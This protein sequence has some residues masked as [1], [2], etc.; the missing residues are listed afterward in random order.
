MSLGFLR[1]RLDALPIL[2]ALLV[3]LPACDS[4]DPPPEEE[5]TDVVVSGVNFTR[6]FAPATDGEVAAVRA[7]WSMRNPSSSNESVVATTT[8][9]GATLAVVE[10]TVTASG[11]APVTHYGLVRV[12]DG[13]DDAPVLVVHHGG[14]DG[15]SVSAGSSNT[16]VVQ[17]VS[18]FGAVA[19]DVVLVVPVYRSET[20]STAGVGGLGASYTAGGTPS[21]WDYDVD[22]SIAMLDAALALFD[23]E[24]DGDRVA[25][26]G[27]SRGG[28]TAALH[29]VRDDRIDGLVDYYGPTDFFNADGAQFLA[30][31]LLA[32]EPDAPN[33]P[34]IGLP[35]AQY[36]YDEV[37]DALRDGRVSEADARLE[38]VRRSASVFQADLPATQVHHHYRDGV[39]TV[40][41]SLAFQA[42]AEGGDGGPFEAF[43]YG[44]PATGTADL[45]GTFHSPD[46]TAEMRASIP[47]VADFLTRR[48]GIGIGARQLAAA[49]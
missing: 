39:V 5:E 12:P 23:D 2:L 7:D 43:F 27:F 29:A 8:L 31:L 21:P 6:L 48:L 1:A 45:S 33:N 35:G 22:D 20:L 28:N 24:T 32:F 30:R 25:A 37:L 41:F 19:D 44:T 46:A 16:G 3:A 34:V 9:G 13:A 11:S 14:D 10:H 40:P 49:Q 47:V 17:F 36:L 26:I 38:V 18:T 4:N 15:F 42:A